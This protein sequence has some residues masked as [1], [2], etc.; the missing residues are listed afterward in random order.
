MS[1]KVICCSRRPKGSLPVQCSCTG[2]S[3]ASLEVRI[4]KQA[5]K[6]SLHGFM[7]GYTNLSDDK[8]FTSHI[9]LSEKIE[10]ES[11]FDFF[12]RVE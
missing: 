9:V 10:S 6:S 3:V 1:T 7:I 4:L 2:I 5:K 11:F 8:N 12:S